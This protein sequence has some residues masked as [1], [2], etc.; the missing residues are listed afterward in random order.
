MKKLLKY[1]IINVEYCRNDYILC[2]NSLKTMVFFVTKEEID[3]FLVKTLISC[4]NGNKY[5]CY[6]T[7]YTNLK[8][9]I[10]KIQNPV[11]FQYGGKGMLDRPGHFR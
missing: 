4:G 10:Q 1:S 11:L 5:L 9:K 6:E 7:R 2:R 3:I 8:N